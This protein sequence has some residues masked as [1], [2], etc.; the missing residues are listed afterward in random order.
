MSEQKYYFSQMQVTEAEKMWVENKAKKML[1]PQSLVVRQLI[2]D[3][4]DAERDTDS[5]MKLQAN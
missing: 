3:R 4:I 5:A 1:V 2:Q